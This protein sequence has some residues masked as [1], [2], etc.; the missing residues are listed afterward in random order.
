M[1]LTTLP[2]NKNYIYIKLVSFNLPDSAQPDISDAITYVP[3]N[4]YVPD[5][6][7]DAAVGETL[8]AAC[9]SPGA[10]RLRPTIHLFR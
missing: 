8:T 1:K 9:A 2:A 3:V 7:M 4:F 5:T 6:P 10:R